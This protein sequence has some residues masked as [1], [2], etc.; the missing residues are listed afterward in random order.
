VPLP[1]RLTPHKLRHTY[2]SL[3]VALGVDPGSVMDQLGH[4]DASFTLR[5]Y[6]HGMRRDQA[7]RGALPAGWP[8]RE[9]E[10]PRRSGAFWERARQDLNLRPFAPELESDRLPR[11]RIPC[12]YGRS[13]ASAGPGRVRRS[14]WIPADPGSAHVLAAHL[15]GVSGGTLNRDC[16]TS[17]GRGPIFAAHEASAP[18]SCSPA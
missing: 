14:R 9:R 11:R 18:A 1:E 3:L 10:K 6:R 8:G 7:S 16:S 4:T 15:L 5:V 17:I 12:S 2:A 13:G